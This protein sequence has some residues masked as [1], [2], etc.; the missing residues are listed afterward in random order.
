VT[1]ANLCRRRR[2]IP[3]AERYNLMPTID[4]W[5]IRTA[6]ALLARQR[7]RG[8]G[9]AGVYA[10]NHFGRLDRDDEFLDFVQASSP[11]GVAQRP[12]CFEITET[13]A[14]DDRCRRPTQF[15]ALLRALGCR[16]ALDDFGVGVSSFTYLKHCRSTT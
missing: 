3:A 4:R 11:H 1:T 14:V 7:A 15:M 6:F 12:I 8:T 9:S 2:F 16:F 10:I 5:V 13:T